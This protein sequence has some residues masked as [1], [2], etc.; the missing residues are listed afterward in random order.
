M[1]VNAEASACRTAAGAV[2]SEGIR[3]SRRYCRSASTC[4]SWCTSGSSSAR[5]PRKRK[6]GIGKLRGNSGS[7]A[8]GGQMSDNRIVS[9]GRRSVKQGALLRLQPGD[10]PAS[11]DPQVEEL[12]EVAAAGLLGQGLETLA[13]GRAVAEGL[14]IGPQEIKEQVVA[15]AGTQRVE[16]QGSLKIDKQPVVIDA[17]IA[18]H[19]QADGLPGLP[20]STQHVPTTP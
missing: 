6:S 4:V 14:E 12:L 5:S 8:S 9:L 7:R 16:K 1:L 19:R 18:A 11:P 20:V 15:Q 13:A 2:L 17:A 10:I 3:I